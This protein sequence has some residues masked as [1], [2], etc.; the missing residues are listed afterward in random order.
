MTTITYIDLG[1]PRDGDDVLALGEN[2]CDG[3]LAGCRAV[4][5]A[6]LLQ[7]V[8]YLEDVREVLLRVTRDRAAIV[9]R[10]EVLG[11]FLVRRSAIGTRVRGGDQTYVFAGDEATAE[12][13]VRDDLDPK[14]ASG[15]QQ[16]D[17]LVL[18]VSREGR[19]FDLNC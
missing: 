17:L 10:R 16:P 13:R 12:G 3:D 15:L 9:V 11:S 19:I 8:G 7:A 5:L 1:R 14:L 6:H 2:P 18:D 4:L